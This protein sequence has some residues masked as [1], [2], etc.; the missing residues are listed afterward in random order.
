MVSNA[1]WRMMTNDGDY[2]EVDGPIR[3]M[4]YRADLLIRTDSLSMQGRLSLSAL[5]WE[6]WGGIFI[7]A[8]AVVVRTAFLLGVGLSQEKSEMKK[9]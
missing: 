4:E 1:Q 6:D 7:T 8:Q 3:L 9:N 2:F 5:R